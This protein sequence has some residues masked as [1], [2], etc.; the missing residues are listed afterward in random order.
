[1]LPTSLS[2]PDMKSDSELKPQLDI[3]LVSLLLCN[4][5]GLWVVGLLLEP[6]YPLIP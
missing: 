1:M 2:M 5:L 3:D 4:F 6:L